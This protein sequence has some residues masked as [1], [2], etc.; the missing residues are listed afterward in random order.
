MLQNGN[1]ENE[2]VTIPK[3]VNLLTRRYQRI[4]ALAMCAVMTA[5]P[6]TA[7]AANQI[8]EAPAAAEAA[9]APEQIVPEILPDATPETPAPLPE[10]LPAEIPEEVPAE[11]A[12]PAEDPNKVNIVMNNVPL[13]L[14]PYARIYQDVTY[15]PVRAFF[16]LFGCTVGWDGVKQKVT[17]TRSD[18]DMTLQVG[19][20]LIE[21]NGRAWYMACPC[22]NLDG[23]TMIHIREVAKIFSAAVAWNGETHTVFMAGTKLL[24]SG[25]EYYGEDL[26][27][28]AR[29]VRC[30]AGNQCL[31]GKIGVANVIVNRMRSAGFPNTAEGVIFDRRFGVQF[32]PSTSKAIYKEPSEECFLAAK[33]AMEG[34]ET[35]PDCF[36]FVSVKSAEKSWA[37]RN[38]TFYGIIE[39]HAFYL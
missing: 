39:G 11:P 16:E 14:E 29:I 8:P 26:L 20:P 27:W 19:S 23:V 6:F 2:T 1:N 9:P 5:M 33:L 18:I 35:A 17:V 10:E 34:Y 32:T 7:F 31:E 36:Y 12:A 15:V 38:R 3:D 25:D 37:G 21:I 24:P 28:I 4:L 22:L 30:E 13:H